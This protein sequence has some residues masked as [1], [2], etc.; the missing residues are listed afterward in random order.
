VK[1]AGTWR[2]V[3]RAVDQHGQVAPRAA[4]TRST[5][6]AQLARAKGMNVNMAPAVTSENASAALVEHRAPEV[7]RVRQQQLHKRVCWRRALG[8]WPP[9]DC[10]SEALRANA[11]K[12]DSFEPSVQVATEA[13]TAEVGPGVGVVGLV[14]PAGSARTDRRTWRARASPLSLP[15]DRLERDETQSVGVILGQLGRQCDRRLRCSGV[16]VERHHGDSDVAD[17]RFAFGPVV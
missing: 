11:S 14:R 12:A 15:H 6:P 7:R 9:G 13:G 17:R 10:D 5:C 1:V 2:Y 8:P 3:Y 4:V 16:A